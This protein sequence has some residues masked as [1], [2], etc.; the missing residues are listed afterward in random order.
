M[1][2]IQLKSDRAARSIEDN[3]INIDK[4]VIGEGI[5]CNVTKFKM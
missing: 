1:Q 4:K 5:F 3:E 2:I